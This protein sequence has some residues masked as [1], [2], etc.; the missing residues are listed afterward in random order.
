[1]RGDKEG[2]REIQLK[3]FVFPDSRD[4]LPI[5]QRDDGLEKSIY[6]TDIALS[7]HLTHLLTSGLLGM[8][9]LILVDGGADK[10]ECQIKAR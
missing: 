9:P 5:D 8:R 1:V 6:W 2:G 4:N 10:R 7:E 3:I